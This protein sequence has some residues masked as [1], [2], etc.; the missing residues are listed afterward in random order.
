MLTNNPPQNDWPQ[1]SW[2]QNSWPQNSQPQTNFNITSYKKISKTIK[3]H[4]PQ[5]NLFGKKMTSVKMLSKTFYI[6]EDF[7][8]R[9]PILGKYQIKHCLWLINGEI[10]WKSQTLPL[11]WLYVSCSWLD[12]LDQLSHFFG[13]FKVVFKLVISSR[14]IS[15]LLRQFVRQSVY[16]SVHQTWVLR[17]LQEVFASLPLSKC[18][19][20]LAHL[21]TAYPTLFHIQAGVSGFY[22]W[23]LEQPMRPKQQ[24]QNATTQLFHTL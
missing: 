23:Q 12:T 9:T 14:S 3:N 17:R 4:S 18:I 7:T 6:I 10:Y 20:T 11:Q 15:K 5:D 21:H 19:T 2:P 24:S 22:W 1:N 16:H 8:A 13:K